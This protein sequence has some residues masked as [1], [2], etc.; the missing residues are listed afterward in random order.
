MRTLHADLTTAQRTAKR[1]PYIRLAFTKS[2]STSYTYTT[3]DSPSRIMLVRHTEEAY[4]DYAVII[5]ANPSR[6]LPDLEGY[7]CDVGYGYLCSGDT[8]RYSTAAPLWVKK[9]Q[10][11]SKP[12]DVN[13]LLF[14][15]GSWGIL[16]SIH[17]LGW[18]A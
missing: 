8:N 3:A 5:L 10:D 1:T 2:G 4:N 15:E 6:D 14:L 16:R 7:R 12:G 9:Q 17:D 18:S 11:T 13:S